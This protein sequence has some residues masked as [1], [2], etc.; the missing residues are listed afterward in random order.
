[1]F[2]S[3]WTGYQTILFSSY[4]ERVRFDYQPLF[5]KWARPSS[6]RTR[7]DPR[8]RLK[9]SLGASTSPR[10][11]IL[12]LN[13]TKVFLFIF[14]HSLKFSSNYKRYSLLFHISQIRIFRAKL[15]IKDGCRLTISKS[16]ACVVAGFWGV[17]LFVFCKVSDQTRKR[18]DRGEGRD[19][20][21][22]ETDLSGFFLSPPPPRFSCW[23][24]V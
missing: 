23:T 22:R 7:Q 1:M 24:S 9:S 18:W 8:E 10:I 17:I 6:G 2:M 3:W 20:E 13:Q 21:G 11:R 16:V 15:E 4:G 14:Y 5:G 19:E 12:A